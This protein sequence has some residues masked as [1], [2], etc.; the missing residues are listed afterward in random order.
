MNIFTLTRR[1]KIPNNYEKYHIH[2]NLLI[3]NKIRNHLTQRFPDCRWA[4]T[5]DSICVNIK[6]QSSPWRKESQIVHAIADYA[7]YYADSYNYDHTDINSDY[8]NVNFFGVYKNNIIADDYIQSR[9]T[10]DTQQAESEFMCRYNKKFAI[11]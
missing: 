7:Y 11:K 2:N 6:L 10:R 3:A 9:I 4:V 1:N 8:C 5:S